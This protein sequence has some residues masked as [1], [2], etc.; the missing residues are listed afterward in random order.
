MRILSEPEFSDLGKAKQVLEAL[1]EKK[2]I[3]HVIE[4][5][6]G[7]DGVKIFIGKEIGITGVDECSLITA[8][9]KE[10]GE[11]IGTL[12]VIGPMRMDYS[13]IIS[14]VDFTS[15][16]LSDILGG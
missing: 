7:T 5:T 14:V 11:P 16:L 4:Q 1:E 8:S 10:N 3:L 15:K 13:K 9:Y 6:M 12:G 2:N